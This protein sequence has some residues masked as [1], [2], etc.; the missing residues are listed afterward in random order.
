MASKEQKPF[1]WGED[2]QYDSTYVDIPS[3]GQTP[4]SETSTFNTKNFISPPGANGRNIQSAIIRRVFGLAEDTADGLIFLLQLVISMAM[5]DVPPLVCET[6]EDNVN[7]LLYCFGMVIAYAKRKGNVEGV[8]KNTIGDA[9]SCGIFREKTPEKVQ[10]IHE[11]FQ[12]CHEQKDSEDS[13][14][15]YKNFNLEWTLETFNDGN[16][17]LC[18]R[19]QP[20]LNAVHA[21]LE[22]ENI[23]VPSHIP[24]NNEDEHFVLRLFHAPRMAIGYTNCIDHIALVCAAMQMYK[25]HEKNLNKWTFEDQLSV[26]LLLALS[27]QS[28][29]TNETPNMVVNRLYGCADH[30]W[31]SDDS[32]N[33]CQLPKVLV[34]P[35]QITTQNKEVQHYLREY[36]QINLNCGDIPLILCFYKQFVEKGGAFIGYEAEFDLDGYLHEAAS[37]ITQ[38]PTRMV[39][40]NGYYTLDI[41][42]EY[43]EVEF[44]GEVLIVP[45]EEHTKCSGSDTSKEHLALKQ[46]LIDLGVLTHP[47][48]SYAEMSDLYQKRVNELCQWDEYTQETESIHQIQTQQLKTKPKKRYNDPRSKHSQGSRNYKNLTLKDHLTQQQMAFVQ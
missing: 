43:D 21:V 34:T 31:I 41:V 32:G 7:Y 48:A 25:N 12:W 36:H 39:F 3:R 20:V 4:F 35:Q 13:N 2:P 8:T 22:H 27:R 1:I 17:Q 5:L 37:Q 28:F 14:D 44:E 26:N 47:F 33:S 46:K 10:K 24:L 45:N 38:F 11:G 15:V 16:P 6:N 42:P 9:F 19:I 23:K 40:S 29:I 30:K 18:R